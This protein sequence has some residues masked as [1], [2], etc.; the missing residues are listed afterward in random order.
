MRSDIP[1]ALTP[2]CGW[3]LIYYPLKELLALK[4]CL[5]EII[6]VLGYK[7]KLVKTEIKSLFFSKFRKS[8]IPLH[9]VDQEKLLGT[10][11]AVKIAL[12]KTHSEDIL[13][14]C[15]DTPLIKRETFHALIHT[16]F[17]NKSTC[18]V[19]TA[20]LDTPNNLGKIIRDENNQI[21]A[22]KESIDI[23]EPSPNTKE[24][25]NSGTYV[26]S[27]EVL[28]HYL[29]KIPL[30]PQKKEYFLTEIIFLLYNDGFKIHALLSHQ[31]EALGIN[32][33]EDLLQAQRI[34]Q[35][36]INS[37][38]IKQG[39]SIVEPQTTFIDDGVR[40]GKQTK[41]YPFTFI[42]KNVIIG[43]SCS[44][45]PFIHLREGTR[46]ANSTQLGNFV[47]VVRSQIGSNV[48][49]KHFSYIGDTI[50]KDKVNIGAGTVVANFDG[51]NK[52]K[53]IIEK[54]AFIGSDTV[55]V[56]PLK[57]GK[58]ALTGAGAIVTKDVAPNIVVVG[59]PAKVLKK[60]K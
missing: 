12:P 38:F 29:E 20:Y 14:T 11:D 51:K 10:A 47:E 25:L 59:V 4:K 44:I 7:N 58:N 28:Y 32:T 57:I 19:L 22:I 50:I 21:M 54:N 8:Q 37:E 46:I 17:K 33:Q 41:I 40:I 49:V 60:R 30:H 48:K 26:F 15:A 5:K 24:E 23:K 39:I 34:M 13:I 52:H 9:F 18:T 1:K 3:P 2:L 56:A 45:G 35:K 27:R 36:R 31:E 16:Y 6:V 53:T 55:L 43:S 42:E